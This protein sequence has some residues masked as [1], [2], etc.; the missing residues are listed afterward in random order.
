[1]NFKTSFIFGAEYSFF[2]FFETKYGP[3]AKVIILFEDLLSVFRCF[4]FCPETAVE[5]IEP[6]RSEIRELNM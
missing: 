2:N 3:F 1:M 4:F 5:R 6:C